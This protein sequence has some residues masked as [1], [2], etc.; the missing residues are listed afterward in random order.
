MGFSYFKQREL[1][2]KERFHQTERTFFESLLL[3]IASPEQ[4]RG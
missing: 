4:I 3:G 1:R 2:V